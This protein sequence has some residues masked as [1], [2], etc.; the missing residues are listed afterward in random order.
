MYNLT[1]ITSI[2]QLSSLFDLLKDHL[3]LALTKAPEYEATDVIDD[4]MRGRSMM[5]YATDSS[6][7]IVGIV[8]TQIKYYPQKTVGL[9]HLLGGT[10]IHKWVHTIKTLADYSV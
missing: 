8:T 5:W 7:N 9:I 4:V 2:P 10:D 1:P 6:D 3:D